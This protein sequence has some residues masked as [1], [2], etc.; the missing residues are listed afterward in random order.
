[1]E[2]PQSLVPPAGWGPGV[3][4]AEV[5]SALADCDAESAL[6]VIE[7]MERLKRW[8]DG[9]TVAATRV[10]ALNVTADHID[11]YAR[12]HEGE[13]SERAQPMPPTKPSSPSPTTSQ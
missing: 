3:P 9:V 6:G 7:A 12:D 1:M 10:L 4:L 11:D 5:A 13:L 2:V 8:A